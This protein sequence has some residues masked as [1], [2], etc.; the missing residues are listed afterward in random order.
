MLVEIIS[1]EGRLL[2]KK[3]KGILLFCKFL[4]T[5]G[6][7]KQI[8]TIFQR[9]RKNWKATSSRTFIASVCKYQ[10]H[11]L[12]FTLNSSFTDELRSVISNSATTETPLCTALSLSII[13]TLIRFRKPAE[14]HAARSITKLSEAFSWLPHKNVQ[15]AALYK[16]LSAQ[17]V[18]IVFQLCITRLAR[19]VS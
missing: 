7:F 17:K 14:V 8:S 11:S 5:K 6:S 15:K 4:K 3:K 13:S 9:Q 2:W 19:S 18:L 1:I 16:I 10:Q 12:V